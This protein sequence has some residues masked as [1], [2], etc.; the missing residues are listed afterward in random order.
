[1]VSVG[2][3]EEIKVLVVLDQLLDDQERGVGM[4]VVVETSVGKQQRAF[5]VGRQ[6]LVG[7]GIVV[8]SAAH[9]VGGSDGAQKVRLRRPVG[10]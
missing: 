9:G 2:R 7:L 10:K 6:V 5:Q 8:V 3:D 1:V 4:D